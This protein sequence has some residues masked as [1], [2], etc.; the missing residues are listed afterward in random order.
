[1]QPL[2]IVHICLASEA[3]PRLAGF[4]QK[5]FEAMCCQYFVSRSQYTRV[6]AI[7]SKVML[8]ILSQSTC[9]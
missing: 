4:D 5:H 7:A 2:C 3:A 8:T 1:M 6:D 9:V